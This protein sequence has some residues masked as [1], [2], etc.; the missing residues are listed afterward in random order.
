M[1]GKLYRRLRTRARKEN[2]K[3]SSL[4]REGAEVAAGNPTIS[5]E[6]STIREELTKLSCS[7][8]VNRIALAVL[9]GNLATGKFDK[10]EFEQLLVAYDVM[11]RRGVRLHGIKNADE[12]REFVRDIMKGGDRNK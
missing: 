4:I 6:L 8:E 3:I 11:V 5:E 10:R 9:A 7:S 2:R 12:L 1:D